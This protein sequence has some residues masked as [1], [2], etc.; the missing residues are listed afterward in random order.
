M[1]RWEIKGVEIIHR[2]RAACGTGRL[3]MYTQ[4]LQG[5]SL[6]GAT[7]TFPA[8][9]SYDV[10]ILVREREPLQVRGLTQCCVT[11]TYLFIGAIWTQAAASPSQTIRQ[12]S[13]FV[14]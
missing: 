14:F 3:F 5:S 11:G 4:R 1:H 7:I 9:I 2:V 10:K 13:I 6:S 12:S 8:K